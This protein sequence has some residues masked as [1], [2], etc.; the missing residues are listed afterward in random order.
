MTRE[1]PQRGPN[2]DA[3]ARLYEDMPS[4]TDRGE[5]GSG[6]DDSF[7]EAGI[8]GPQ[9]SPHGGDLRQAEDRAISES[10]H[11]SMQPRRNGPKNAKRSDALI[12][13]ELNERFRDDE[14]LDASEILLSV[15]DGR[16]LLT[17]EVPERWMKH[18]AEDIADGV[19]G[20]TAVDNRIRVDSG[21]SSI[22]PGGPV[23]TGLDQRGSGFSSPPP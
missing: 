2:R 22:G 13:E 12:V 17:G 16:V 6:R 18:R 15:E 7:G 5:T 8:G 21:V 20:V 3:G 10:T 1:T 4:V 9:E 19:R 11:R 23:R 14:L